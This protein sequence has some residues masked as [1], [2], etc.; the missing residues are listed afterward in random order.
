M[1]FIAKFWW[2][3][4][5]FKLTSNVSDNVIT[6]DKATLVAYLLIGYEID[7]MAL[8]RLDIHECVF[9]ETTTL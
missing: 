3:M 8:I 5:C 4:V 6:W 2:T 1:H 7:F 9:G